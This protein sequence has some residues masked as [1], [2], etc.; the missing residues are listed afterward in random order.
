MK[1]M[2]FAKWL[3]SSL[4]LLLVSGTF[5]KSDDAAFVVPKKN[6]LYTELKLAQLG[7][8]QEVFD[9]AIKGWITLNKSQS[10]TKPGVISIADLS[11]SSNTKRL[12]V[13]DIL[14]KKIIFNTYVAHGRNSGQEFATSFSNESS[15][16]KSSLGFYI[17]ENTYTGAHGF[18]LKLNGLEKGINDEAK[19]RGIVMHGAP[20]VSESFINQNGRLGR[21]LGCPAVPQE[22]CKS[23]VDSI[24][25]GSC[26][27]IFYPD[28]YYLVKSKLLRS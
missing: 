17:T 28:K 13:I 5:S 7:L 10:L 16:F 6:S 2:R 23:I 18:S 21:S 1:T 22:L 11:Q 14:S 26:F 20:Y 9:T 25:G 3:V 4:L 15:S 27:F 24:K 8:K 19:E 12:Y